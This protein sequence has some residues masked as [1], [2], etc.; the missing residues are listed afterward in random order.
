MT[1]TRQEAHALSESERLTRITLVS[2]AFVLLS[3]IILALV[4]LATGTSTAVTATLSFAGGVSNIFLP[5]TLPLAFIIVP[6]SMAHD[7]KKGFIMSLLFGLG[8]IITLAVYG[9]AVAEIGKY[10]GLDRATRM[11]TWRTSC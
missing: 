7:Y 1:E 8:L 2:T 4:Y 5:C 9:A 10:V 11:A 6:L 3:I